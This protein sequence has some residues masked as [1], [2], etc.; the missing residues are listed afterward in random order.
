[1]FCAPSAYFQILS[2]F[3]AFV[4]D[5]SGVPL[6]GVQPPRLLL[7]LD[8]VLRLIDCG[9]Y[10]VRSPSIV[11][12]CLRISAARAAPGWVERS[13]DR[14]RA[15]INRELEDHDD[16]EIEGAGEPGSALLYDPCD[17]GEAPNVAP[18]A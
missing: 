5:A 14:A 2:P 10:E 16:T 11:T 3:E 1:M 7:W 15:P 9:L 6:R 8:Q 12:P 13:E 18:I 4:R 17:P